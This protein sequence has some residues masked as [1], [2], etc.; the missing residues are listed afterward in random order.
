VQPKVFI[1]HAG[2]DR[3]RFVEGFT[4]KLREQGVDAWFSGWEILPGDSLVEK[5]PFR[6][7]YSGFS[8]VDQAR[9]GKPGQNRGRAVGC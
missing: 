8:R 3:D 5:R 6:N 7:R 2:E 1:S 4:T 9:N